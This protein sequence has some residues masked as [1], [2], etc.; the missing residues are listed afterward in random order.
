MLFGIPLTS[1]GSENT[2][3]CCSPGFTNSS[4]DNTRPTTDL[5]LP[6]GG[7]DGDTCVVEVVGEAVVVWA[8]VFVSVVLVVVVSVGVATEFGAVFGVDA[9]TGE[10]WVVGADVVVG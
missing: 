3:A 9:V 7:G 10:D 5:T 6:L 4:N 8:S 1:C 2:F